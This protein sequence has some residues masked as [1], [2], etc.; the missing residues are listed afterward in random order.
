MGII[1]ETSTK[2]ILKYDFD[3]DVLIPISPVSKQAFSR[4][5]HAHRS[6][7]LIT[8]QYIAEE[9]IAQARAFF[10]RLRYGTPRDTT[11]F[12]VRLPDG[13]GITAPMRPFSQKITLRFTRS[14]S[15]RM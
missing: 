11:H 14:F 5:T 10:Q 15:V 4:I 12:K 3:T 6:R 7:Q 8:E 2:L 13:L 9:S 1:V